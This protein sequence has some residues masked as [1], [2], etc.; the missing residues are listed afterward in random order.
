MSARSRTRSRGTMIINLR[1]TMYPVVERSCTRVS[2][3]DSAG[4]G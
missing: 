3:F 4:L 1:K 2:G